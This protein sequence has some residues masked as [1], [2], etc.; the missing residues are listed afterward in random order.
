M[1]APL[2]P[3]P[4]APDAA[5]RIRERILDAAT[6]CM[7]EEGLHGRAHA[8]IAERAGVSRP[9]VYK[10]V[11]DQDAILAAIVDREFDRFVDAVLP[12]LRSSDDLRAHLVDAVVFVVGYAH[13]NELL[14]KALRD[15]PE[16]ILPALTTG[17]GPLLERAAE[18]FEEQLGRALELAGATGVT[19][20]DAVDWMFRI[21]VSL[22]AAPGAAEQDPEDVRRS[23]RALVQLTGLSGDR[24]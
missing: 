13:Q 7:V 2:R 22:I 14:Q 6:A 21:I 11:G 16:L 24:V 15:H 8:R 10:Y 20:R 5:E 3:G 9:T 12:Y 1:P 17:S 4:A 19:A 23:V 18:V